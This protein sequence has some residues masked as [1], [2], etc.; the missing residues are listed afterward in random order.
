[1]RPENVLSGLYTNVDTVAVGFFIACFA[2]FRVFVFH[3]FILI[4]VDFF[5][6]SL[7]RSLFFANL[8]LLSWRNKKRIETF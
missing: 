4:A 6:A 2:S 1:M 7:C 5:Q 3:Y 8:L